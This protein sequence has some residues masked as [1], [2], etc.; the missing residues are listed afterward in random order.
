MH[1]VERRK[2]GRQ[3]I[4]LVYRYIDTL[5]KKREMGI[6]KV[7]TKRRWKIWV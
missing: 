3:Q 2:I 6:L 1:Q 5:N 4:S 7:V